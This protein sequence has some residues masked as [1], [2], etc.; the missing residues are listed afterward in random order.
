MVN[1]ICELLQ[2]E[3]PI[4]LGGML[5]AGR[6]RLVVA[7][8]EAGGLGVLGAGRM[9]ADDLR[10]ELDHIKA[11][12]D[13]PFG[14]NIPLRS[15]EPE[16]LIRVGLDA[17]VVVFTTSG[18]NP[19]LFTRQIQSS[20]AKV[21]HVAATVKQALKAQQAGVDAVVA[22]GCDSGG[23]LGRD[24]VGTMAL[25]PQ[26]VDAVNIPVIA[27]GGIVDGRGMAAAFALGAAAI[28]MGTRF[29]AC[30]EC[31]IA[32]DY[33]QAVLLAKDTDTQVVVNESGV[34][35]RA[36]KKEL[37]QEAIGVVSRIGRQ[38]EERF[39]FRPPGQGRSAGQ[40]AGLIHEVLPAREIII[41]IMTDARRI[42]GEL[43]VHLL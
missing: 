33:K 38:P 20:G 10:Q 15:P 27:A 37:L 23:L 2:I 4:L 14:I 3:Y 22:E 26:V 41:S 18:G 31:D 28:Q 8:S 24:R 21:I 30:E 12:T 42:A 19:A 6:A 29:L 16:V 9:N 13:K 32:S 1:P 25:V 35:R 17:G 36:M 7:V 39:D 5:N 40:G 11:Y 43:P 34:A